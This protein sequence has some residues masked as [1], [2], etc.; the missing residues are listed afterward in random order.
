MQKKTQNKLFLANPPDENYH[1]FELGDQEEYRM[2]WP[3][4][5]ELQI[6]EIRGSINIGGE[7]DGR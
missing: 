7:E 6:I 5:V 1:Y 3:L 4:V 2:G